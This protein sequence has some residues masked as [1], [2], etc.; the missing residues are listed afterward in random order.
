M[1][2]E[3]IWPGMFQAEAG[4]AMLRAADTTHISSLIR[5]M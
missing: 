5:V 2:A 4:A 1:A 3:S